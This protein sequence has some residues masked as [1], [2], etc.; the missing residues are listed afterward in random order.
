MNLQQMDYFL[1]AARCLNFT[2]AAS[3]LFITQ[4]ALTKQIAMAWLTPWGGRLLALPMRGWLGFPVI[5]VIFH[6]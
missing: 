4:P 5:P 1:E 3:H 2:V 6:V